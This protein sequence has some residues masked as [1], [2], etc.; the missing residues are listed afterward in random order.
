M[1]T[2]DTSKA[3]SIAL[4]LKSEKAK[5]PQTTVQTLNFALKTN[6]RITFLHWSLGILFH[7]ACQGSHVGE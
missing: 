4:S 3:A 1:P 6:C 5:N 2:K 7:I